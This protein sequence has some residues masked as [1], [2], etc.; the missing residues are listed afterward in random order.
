LQLQGALVKFL[1]PK[2]INRTNL[3][4]AHVQAL[5]ELVLSHWKY[6]GDQ[7]S[8]EI[9]GSLAELYEPLFSD[10]QIQAVSRYMAGR[11]SAAD[12]SLQPSP[13]MDRYSWVNF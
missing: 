13:T 6:I 8:G 5:L 12:A 9:R 3:K 11:M 4:P 7:N 2:P 10:D 1:R